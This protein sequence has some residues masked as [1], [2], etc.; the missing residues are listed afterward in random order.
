MAMIVGRTRGG[1]EW[2]PQ[3][4]TALSPQARV[5]CG[6]CYKVC[7]KQCHSHEAAAAAA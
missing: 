2:I 5:G 7:P 1:S 3:F 6:R 4:I